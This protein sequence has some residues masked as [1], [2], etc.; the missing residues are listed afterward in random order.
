MK[1]SV[2]TSLFNYSPDKFDLFGAFKNWSKYADE[3]VIAT[4]ED[5]AKDISAIVGSEMCGF[6]DIPEFQIVSCSQTSLNH[7]LFDGKLKNAA[8][9]ACSNEIVIQQ[10]MDERL[11]G[12]V[13]QWKLLAEMFGK[14][15]PPF[16]FMIPVIDLFQDYDHYKDINS[17]WYLH[18]KTGSFRGAVNFAHRED[19]TLDISKSDS[20]ELIDEKGNLIP[21]YGDFRFAQDMD[22]RYPHI[23]HLGY[24]DLTKRAEHNK[25]RKKCWEA[26]EGKEVEVA[27]TVDQLQIE[28]KPKPH[29]FKPQWWV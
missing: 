1:A 12:E 6:W 3:I 14:V 15:T 29:G 4:F 2:Y 23:I 13:E 18:T 21:Y 28:N 24:L 10:D 7:P 27:T 5:Q 22:T 17:K 9:Q 16:S 25:F 20:C 26:M 8:L 19:G 11:G